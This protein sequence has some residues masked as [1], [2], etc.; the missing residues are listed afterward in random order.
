MSGTVVDR[1][2]R[3]IAG[4]T[5]VMGREIQADGASLGQRNTENLI[6]TASGDDG[7]FAVRGIGPGN[8]MVIADHQ[9]H[10]RST[11][12]ELPAG[13]T[14]QQLTLT[15]Q[16]TGAIQG[17]VRS[18]GKPVEAVI[19]LRP[20]NAANLQTTVRSGLD[21]SYRLDRIAAGR[22]VHFTIIEGERATT[23]SAGAGRNIE[24]KP[25]ETLTLD[26]DLT[27]SGVAVVVHIASPG[28]VV[29]YGY[30]IL[31]MADLSKVP[32]LPT[33]ISEGRD[34][35]GWTRSTSAGVGRRPS[36]RSRARAHPPRLVTSRNAKLRGDPSDPEGDGRD[37]AGRGRL[38]DSLQVHD[39]ALRAVPRHHAG[40]AAAAAE[41]IS[42]RSPGRSA[43]ASRCRP[44]PPPGP[45][46]CAS[47]AWPSTYPSST[48]TA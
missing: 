42:E 8:Y 25:G 19:V 5:V 30:A 13:T 1:G 11:T 45:T 22:Y 48:G 3:P 47:R 18:N 29:K 46:R 35:R 34:R 20:Q 16:P 12:L 36:A 21:G 4:A 6:Q 14:D 26:V 15:L 27:P 7:S 17:V 10:G 23:G 41:V 31:G 2:G 33:T 44:R 9:V 39:D 24:V 38:A 37:A 28:D 40:A 43:S 32:A